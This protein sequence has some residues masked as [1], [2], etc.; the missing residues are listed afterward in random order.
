LNSLT[1]NPQAISLSSTIMDREQGC[2]SVYFQTENPNLGKF[3]GALQW[4]LLLYL[5]PIL[6]Y[7][8]AIWYILRPFG[9]C[10]SRPIGIGTSWLFG[11]FSPEKN[12]ATLIS[13]IFFA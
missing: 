13:S 12:L 10:I 11:V 6:E 8:T 4:K 7:F 5:M 2:Q 1:K 3:W 9:I